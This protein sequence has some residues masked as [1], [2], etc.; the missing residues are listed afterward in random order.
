MYTVCVCCYIAMYGVFGGAAIEVN[1]DV[2]GTSM[3]DED[4]ERYIV[5]SWRKDMC[6]LTK[7]QL[8]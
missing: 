7:V 8:V 4:V 2:P 5:R 3:T 1:V 6:T